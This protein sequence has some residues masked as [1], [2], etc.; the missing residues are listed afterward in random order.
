M[1]LS[2]WFGGMRDAFP[3]GNGAL[4]PT[5]IAKA[6]CKNKGGIFH[7]PET[8]RK[9]QPDYRLIAVGLHLFHH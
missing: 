7:E 8:S 5:V 6:L 2:C 9:T 1:A 4:L 3:M